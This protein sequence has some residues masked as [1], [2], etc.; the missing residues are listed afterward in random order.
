MLADDRSGLPAGLRR[1][2]DADAD[3]LIALVVAA[4]EEYPGCVLDLPG[5]DDDLPTPGTTAAQRGS[6]WWVVEI[7]GRI[8]ASIGAGPLDRRACVE[9]KRLYV[10]RD[11][12]GRGL[13]TRLIEVV[14][15]HAA[16]LGATSVELWSDTR[17]AA[18]HHRYEQLGYQRTGEERQL[19]DPSDTTE[20]RLVKPITPAAADVTIGWDGPH[21]AEVASLTA[22][23]DGWA[24]A[25]DLP[26]R[27][28]TIT[29][30]VDGSWRTRRAEVDADGSVRR[31][32][33][34]GAGTWWRDGHEAPALAGATDV[35]VEVS[36]LT[37]TLPIRRLLAAGQE[38]AEV[39]AAWVR[40]P[41]DTVQRLD[42]RYTRTGRRT[43]RYR[44][45]T[46]FEADLTVDE[47]GL[48]ERYG[49]VW[50]RT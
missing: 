21:G 23:P 41:G 2:A 17:F 3:G 27:E 5:I 25:A 32:T 46:G 37:N 48:V 12:R 35:D 6:P 19:H 7:D 26:D 50:H 11:H 39:A 44:S 34:D 8:V 24:L 45:T 33:S 4:F 36:P 13:A 30:E 40:V 28:V 10:D 20:Y 22:L 47:H 1:V 31:L 14:E 16:G 38:D 18:A 43:W 42:Q 15:R 29:V 9:L 49:E